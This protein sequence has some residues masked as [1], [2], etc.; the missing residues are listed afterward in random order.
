MLEIQDLKVKQ[1]KF[2]LSVSVPS[3]SP[4]I[5]ALI[6]PSGSGK[7]TLLAALAGFL[8]ISAG[9]LRWKRKDITHLKPA[10]RPMAILFQD[11]NLF[12]H[13]TAER[14]IALAVTQK[15]VLTFS[16]KQ[17]I[18]AALTRVGLDGFGD[19]KPAQ[20]SGGQQ[21][22][23]AL[24]RIL[25]QDKPILLL[26]EPFNALGPALKND[27]LDLLQ[28]LANERQCLV[29]MVTHDPEDAMR[30]AKETLVVNDHKVSLPV[31]TARLFANPPPSLAAY[32]GAGKK[33]QKSI[34]F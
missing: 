34:S 29:L 20:L 6:G 11:N 30:I 4:K 10:E 15:R 23:V 5:Y 16:I 24:A 13:L 14:N 1:G 8:P 31:P 19:Y 26:D 17:K 32:L 33:K 9:T 7:S 25:L 28:V 22:R 3:M 2:N 27:M 12:P 21:G 18:Q